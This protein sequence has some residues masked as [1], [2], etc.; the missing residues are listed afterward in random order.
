MEGNEFYAASD[1]AGLQIGNAKF[2]YGYEVT[3]PAEPKDDE[4]VDWCF[5]AKLDGK[6]VMRRT[7]KQLRSA[8][9]EVIDT[10][11][12]GVCEFFKTHGVVPNTEAR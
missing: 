5:T 12:A 11:M 7:S 1:Y 9:W 10:L 4:D 3:E 8:K 6:E 2:Y